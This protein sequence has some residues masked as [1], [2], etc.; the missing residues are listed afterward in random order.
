MIQTNA[1]CVLLSKCIYMFQKTLFVLFPAIP[2]AGVAGPMEKDDDDEF[3]MFPSLMLGSSVVLKRMRDA[4][5]TGTTVQKLQNRDSEVCV[6]FEC[7][8]VYMCAVSCVLCC[9]ILCFVVCAYVYVYLCT[10]KVS[11]LCVG[12]ILSA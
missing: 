1:P 8:C 7:V 2:H 6:L 3:C 5:T 12:S 4:H 9:I 11:D 10:Q